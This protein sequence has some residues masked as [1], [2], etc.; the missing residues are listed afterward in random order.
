MGNPIVVAGTGSVVTN[1]SADGISDAGEAGKSVLR[2]ATTAVITG[3]L[4]IFGVGT[5]GLVPAPTSGDV[6]AVRVLGATGAWVDQATGGSG[7][8]LLPPGAKTEFFLPAAPAGWVAM[9]GKTIGNASSGATGRANADTSALFAILWDKDPLDVPIQA[10]DGSPSNRGV[11]A[12]ADY[13]ANK[14]IVVPDMGGV[15]SRGWRAGQTTD[16]SR[17]LGS[18]QQQDVQAHQH[19]IPF[20]YKS[21]RNTQSGG[22][23]NV[24][25]YPGTGFQTLASTGTE[26]RPVNISFLVCLKL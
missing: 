11:S 3:L 16:S 18:F 14:R 10:S 12:A 15:F 7:G 21:N 1:V 20:T 17:R 13:A 9:D 5:K 2:A 24:V 23:E 8:T 22:S 25:E 19:V 6:A 26:T 4:N